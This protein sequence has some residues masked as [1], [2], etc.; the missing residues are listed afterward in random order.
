MP[1]LDMCESWAI[2]IS[3]IQRKMRRKFM[4]TLVF[5]WAAEARIIIWSDDVKRD[6][7]PFEDDHID[8][9]NIPVVVSVSC[10]FV[11]AELE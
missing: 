4:A 3:H 1:S 2:P 8:E 6:D 7:F 11:A 10:L 5:V 9:I